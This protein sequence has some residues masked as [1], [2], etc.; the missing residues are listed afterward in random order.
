MA[1]EWLIGSWDHFL[2]IY[3]HNN[4][5]F[6][7]PNRKWV[8]IPYDN[9]EY[10]FGI[11]Q[12]LYFYPNKEL[13]STKSIDFGFISFKDFEL[14]H[15][16][17]KILIHDDDF[18]FRKLVGDIISKIYNPDNLF[19]RINNL[20]RFISFHIRKDRKLKAGKINKIGKDTRFN[21]KH[22]HLN[23]EYTFI[24]DKINHY[25]VYGLKDWIFRRYKYVSSFYGINTNSI[26]IKEKH[27]L[28]YPRP[29]PIT[30]PYS[31][32]LKY[33]KSAM[34][35]MYYV[36]LS[37]S[38]SRYQPD[39]SYADDNIPTLGINQYNMECMKNH[40]LKNN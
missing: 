38:F 25:N 23:S 12:G 40:T 2:G 20:K 36:E 10:E 14:D 26:S 18:K 15:P 27:K 7:Q 39:K 33:N 28:I 35:D 16:I 31:T 21:Y 19:I 34:E 9:G 3:G 24:N 30:I 37:I 11:N 8:Y 6:Q 17:I 29:E 13:D 4:F 1:W 22:F 32:T 5:W